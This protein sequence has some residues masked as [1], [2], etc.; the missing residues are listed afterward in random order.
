LPILF[1]GATVDELSTQ[2]QGKSRKNYLS[3]FGVDKRTGKGAFGLE[4]SQRSQPF[5]QRNPM[6]GFRIRG[7]PEK[8]LICLD[9]TASTIELSFTGEEKKA[10]QEE[11]KEKNPIR[12]GKVLQAL[13]GA[14]ETTPM[15]IRELSIEE[16]LKKQIEAEKAEQENLPNA[17]E[18]ENPPEE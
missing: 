5:A 14:L 17:K 4:V 13:E 6:R 2:E 15:E 3:L 11:S 9:F 10:E 7:Q 16:I 12:F 8:D 1:F 18:E